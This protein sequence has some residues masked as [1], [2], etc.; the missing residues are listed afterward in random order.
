MLDLTR[1]VKIDDGDQLVVS[2]S[3]NIQSFEY[4]I[5]RFPSNGH[6][7]FLPGSLIA[8][9]D[10]GHPQFVG[11]AAT[12]RA[13]MIQVCVTHKGN[14]GPSVRT[15]NADLELQRANGGVEHLASIPI[16]PGLASG[17]FK[18]LAIAFE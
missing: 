6:G 18:C 12:I 16:P 14:T 1:P 2:V 13:S 9:G 8:T 17:G 4:E 15:I 10:D 5:T 7:G 3:A 11:D